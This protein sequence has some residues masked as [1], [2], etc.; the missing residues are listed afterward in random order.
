MDTY[1]L[2]R[3][4]STGDGYG[5]IG[6]LIS[7][8]GKEICVTYELP[9]IDNKAFVSSIPVGVYICRLKYSLSKGR[10]YELLDVPDRD[11]ILIHIGNSH[12]D[13]EGCI[14]VGSK[15]T[16]DYIVRS[17]IAMGILLTFLPDRFKL[18]ILD[19]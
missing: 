16:D 8:D 10:C 3:K 1:R 5:V 2:V 13:T 6:S 11:G 19:D 12:N 4:R 17:R 9:F 7:P 14:L 15:A 18:I